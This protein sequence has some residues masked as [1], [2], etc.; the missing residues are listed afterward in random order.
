[1]SEPQPGW[2]WC[3]KCQGLF[4]NGNPSKGAC[5]FE[6]PPFAQ[7]GGGGTSAPHDA[8]QSGKYAMIKGES[9]GPPPPETFGDAAQQG[10]WRWCNKCQGLIFAENKTLGVCPKDKKHHDVTGSGHYAI[11]STNGQGHWRWCVKCEGL[12]FS[13][14]G[15]LGDTHQAGVCPKDKK[16][17]DGSQSRDYHLRFELVAG[18]PDVP[19]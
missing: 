1:M 9:H 6:M 7:P 3:H 8:S 16:P 19:K 17:H 10:G 12:F 5:P 4:F 18:P 13:E 2:R 11:A 14:G 15:L